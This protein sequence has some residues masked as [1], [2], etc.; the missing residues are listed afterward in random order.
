VEKIWDVND[1]IQLSG[2]T[3]HEESM[4]IIKFKLFDDVVP[5]TARI[6]RGLAEGRDGHG[7]D[8]TDFHR[9][10]PNCGDGGCRRMLE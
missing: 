5:E 7:Y 8:D 6:F 10:V 1:S 4:G 9:V 2:S 3:I